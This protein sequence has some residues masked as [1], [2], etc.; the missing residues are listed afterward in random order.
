MADPTAT[1]VSFRGATRS[2]E[3]RRRLSRSAP[4]VPPAVDGVDLDIAAGTITGVIGYSGAGKST[5]VRLINGLERPDSGQVIVGGE[6]ISDAGERTLRQ[7][8]G[9]IGMVFQQF[10]LFSSRTVAR[11]VEFP[12][13]IAG[14][15]KAERVRRVAELLEFV[16]IADKADRYPR[17][18]SGGQ[19]QRVGIARALATSP[20]ILLAD[21]ATSALDPDTTAEILSLLRRVNR[22]LG[23]TIVVITHEMDVIRE[24]CDRV[25]VLDHGRLIEQGDV[26]DVFA[27]PQSEITRR[28]VRGAVGDVPS[29]ETL[30]RLR[31]RHTGRFLTVAIRENGSGTVDVADHFARSGVRAS[32]VYGGIVE[33]AQ[34][35]FGAFT[36]SVEGPDTEIDAAVAGL[37]AVTDVIEHESG[38]R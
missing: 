4:S 7:V 2:F 28:L 34:R 24:I 18:L 17:Q 9:D 16:G 13:R 35:P 21:E 14:V 30:E 25:A 37:R 11:N 12:L 31:S 33:L 6:D 38:V 1:A 29:E 20:S 10:N 32:I 26:Y 15:D 8:R 19:K 3:T 36:V 27:R 5:L 23:T 22:E